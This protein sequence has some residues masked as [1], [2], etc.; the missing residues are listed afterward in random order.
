MKTIVCSCIE[1]VKVLSL[2]EKGVSLEAVIQ[3]EE[4]EEKDRELAKKNVWILISVFIQQG[5]TLYSMSEIEK[6]GKE[7]RS[8]VNPPKPDDIC[9]ICYTSGTTSIPKVSTFLL[10]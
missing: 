2:M 4:V 5:I 3:M 7:H 6:I 10:L 1:T 9:T 8:P